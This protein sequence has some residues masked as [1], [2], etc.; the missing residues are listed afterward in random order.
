MRGIYTELIK[1]VFVDA[2]AHAILSTQ[3]RGLRA[4]V[5]AWVPKRHGL[6]TVKSAYRQLYDQQCRL[7]EGDQASS[8]G[9]ITWN[10]IWKLELSPKIQFFLC[11]VVNGFLPTKGVLHRRHVEPLPNCDTCGVDEET[12]KPKI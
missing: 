1:Q 6:Y 5:W 2:D 12:I 9:D 3:V 10:Q 11:R 8:F 4:D 7:L